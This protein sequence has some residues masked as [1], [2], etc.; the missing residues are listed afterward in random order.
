MGEIHSML[1]MEAFLAT[2]DPPSPAPAPRRSP[3]IASQTSLLPW[4]FSAL[5]ALPPNPRPCSQ[6]CGQ[7]SESHSG[8]VDFFFSTLVFLR[9]SFARQV[10][11]DPPSPQL[12]TLE[13]GP[14]SQLLQVLGVSRTIHCFSPA[15]TRCHSLRTSCPAS[16]VLTRSEMAPARQSR[17]P[18]PGLSD[19][20]CQSW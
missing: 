18:E 11:L 2:Q 20:R 5:P 13:G 10:L 19:P 9:D 15:V 17:K 14:Q 7:A 3:Q 1:M 4:G 6:I 16:R 12:E 8:P